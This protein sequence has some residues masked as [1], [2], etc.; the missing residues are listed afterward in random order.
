MKSVSLGYRA[1]VGCARVLGPVIALAP[2]KLGRSVRGRRGVVE[3]FERWAAAHRELN[4]PLVWVHAPSVGEGLQ[5]KAVVEA[6]RGDHS[7]AQFA[8]T[9]FSASAE[10]L[11]AAMPVDFADYLPWDVRADV[12]RALVA[13]RPRV[14]AYTK[15]EA[16][17]VLTAV[18][19]EM[20]IPCVLIAGTLPEGSSRLRWPGRPVLRPTFGRLAGVAAI[21]DEDAARFAQLGVSADVVSVL[22][23][24]AVDSALERARAA[25]PAA[26]FL[27][28]FRATGGSWLVAGSTWKPDERVLIGALK[29][30]WQR[31]L[32]VRLLVAP[33]EPTPGHVAALTH[34]LEAAGCSVQ[35]LSEV[36]AAGVVRADAV[37]IDRVGVLAQLYTIGC[38]AYVGGGFGGAGLHS[39]LEPA[40]AGIPVMHG[41]IYQGSRAAIDLIEVGG[42]VAVRDSAEAEKAVRRWIEDPAHAATAGAQAF[43]YIERHSNAAARTARFLGGFLA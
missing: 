36:E 32:P 18:A 23:D 16:W 11:A 43:G 9:H 31:G 8:F 2:G 41:P 19:G 25:D 22:G 38:M 37:V 39:V 15:T 1:V 7:E 30:V 24:P 20:G 17:P 10:G 29:S 4:R 42:S 3:R 33:H 40:A 26:A 5:A 21:A 27:A 6:L 34:R 12:A 35:T 14:V 28:P 13:L